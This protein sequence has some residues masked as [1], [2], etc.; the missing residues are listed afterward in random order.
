[1]MREKKHPLPPPPLLYTQDGSNVSGKKKEKAHFVW[2]AFTFPNNE[3]KRCLRIS[4]HRT[5]HF[6]A[7]SAAF[8]PKKT[9]FVWSASARRTSETT[10]LLS[11]IFPRIS[12]R[13]G[14]AISPHWTCLLVRRNGWLGGRACN[15]QRER[16]REKRDLG[17][18]NSSLPPPSGPALRSRKQ[19]R[20]AM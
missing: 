8:G 17:W 4:P 16:E 11:P 6:P 12:P 9:Q 18:Q 1:M 3:R 10:S 19:K 14:L 20:A 2:P 7:L 13:T 5:S 15:S